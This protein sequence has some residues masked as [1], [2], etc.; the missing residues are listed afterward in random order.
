MFIL[1]KLSLGLHLQF[2]ALE[3]LAQNLVGCYPWGLDPLI[4]SNGV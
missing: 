4:V 1:S 2:L 3:I